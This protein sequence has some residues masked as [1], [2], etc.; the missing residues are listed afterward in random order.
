MYHD[1]DLADRAKQSRAIRG[2]VRKDDVEVL[3]PEAGSSSRP[4]SHT[5][6]RVS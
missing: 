1:A 5:E 6:T 4:G 2:P 3:M